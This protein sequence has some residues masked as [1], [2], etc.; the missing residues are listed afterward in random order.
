MYALLSIVS[1]VFSAVSKA[2]Y[3]SSGVRRPILPPAALQLIHPISHSVTHLPVGRILMPKCSLQLGRG[4]NNESCFP[5][6]TKTSVLG[7]DSRVMVAFLSEAVV[8]DP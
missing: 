2:P 4:L 5:P 7:T 3:D 1:R 6:E 8:L